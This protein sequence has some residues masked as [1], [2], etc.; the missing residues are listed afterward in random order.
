M[1]Q[2]MRNGV[3]ATS[4]WA[5]QQ[6]P[7]HDTVLNQ[8]KHRMQFNKGVIVNIESMNGHKLLMS[9]RNMENNVGMKGSGGSG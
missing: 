1:L 9:I 4:T 8:E 3:E 2:K 5:M 6:H 7:L